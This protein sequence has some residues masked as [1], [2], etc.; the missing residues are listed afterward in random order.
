MSGVEKTGEVETSP[1]SGWEDGTEETPKGSEKDRGASHSGW[2]PPTRDSGPGPENKCHDT[3]WA[4]VGSPLVSADL[5]LTNRRKR[6]PGWL[7]N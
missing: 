6:Y 2:G 3:D 1:V 5:R 4:A 7:A